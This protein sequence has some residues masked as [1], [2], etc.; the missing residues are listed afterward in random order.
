MLWKLELF[1]NLAIKIKIQSLCCVGAGIYS[2]E[3]C[4]FFFFRQGFC[5]LMRLRFK[6]WSMC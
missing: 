4:A 3:F 2:D 1:G 5:S 6:N